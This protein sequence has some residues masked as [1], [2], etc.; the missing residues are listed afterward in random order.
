MSIQARSARDPAHL[1]GLSRVSSPIG[2]SRDA[3]LRALAS[4][5]DFMGA[6]TEPAPLLAMTVAGP[7]FSLV[8]NPVMSS[9]LGKPAG[10][11]TR[12]LGLRMT[13]AAAALP[14]EVAAF[15]ATQRA[16][17]H[18]IKPESLDWRPEALAQEAGALGLTLALFKTHG[19]LAQVLL[20]NSLKVFHPM[21]SAA[22][23]YSGIYHSHY[24]EE[25]LGWRETSAWDQ[26]LAHSLETFLQLKG[27]GHL[28]HRMMGPRY[29]AWVASLEARAEQ[30][31][32]KSR[33]MDFQ[34]GPLSRLA[35][36]FQP[37]ALTATGWP[38]PVPQDFIVKMSRRPEDESAPRTPDSSDSPSEPRS[39]PEILEGQRLRSALL[40]TLEIFDT[41]R[42][43]AVRKR[44]THDLIAHEDLVKELLAEKFQ[45]MG[46][47]PKA[48]PE[49]VEN[50]LVEARRLHFETVNHK[51]FLMVDRLGFLVAEL[52]RS[53]RQARGEE[54]ENW[55][56]LLDS[57]ELKQWE[58]A[59]VY[60]EGEAVLAN[61]AGSKKETEFSAKNYPSYRRYFE[62]FQVRVREYLSRHAEFVK[63]LEAYGEAKKLGTPA[64]LKAEDLYPMIAKLDITP[65]G[66]GLLRDALDFDPFLQS[67]GFMRMERVLIRLVSGLEPELF[68]ELLQPL[69]GYL[70]AL[71]G[72]RPWL[73]RSDWKEIVGR[74]YL[75]ESTDHP[76]MLQELAGRFEQKI[77]ERF[78]QSGGTSDLMEARQALRD[79]FDR[80]PDLLNLLR[81]HRPE[82][83][84]LLPPLKWDE[85]KGR[86]KDRV[87]QG[88]VHPDAAA[89]ILRW[90]EGSPGNPPD[91]VLAQHKSESLAGIL[92]FFFHPSRT[93]QEQEEFNYLL[94]E[95]CQRE[96]LAMMKSLAIR[97]HNYHR[98]METRSR[99]LAK[100]DGSS[101][102][103]GNGRHET[104]RRA[105]LEMA[106]IYQKYP[107]FRG[108]YFE[109]LE[110]ALDRTQPHSARLNAPIHLGILSRLD[111]GSSVELL[112]HPS[113]G[114]EL[115]RVS[116]RGEDHSS[117]EVI[118]SIQDNLD[119]RL[120]FNG[121]MKKM[122]KEVEPEFDGDY[123]MSLYIPRI[124]SEG[125]RRDVLTWA[126]D[127]LEQRPRLQYIEVYL[128]DPARGKAVADPMDAKQY[129][130]Y[131]VDRLTSTTE[132]R[133]KILKTE[134][135]GGSRDVGNYLSLYQLLRESSPMVDLESEAFHYLSEARRQFPDNKTVAG[136]MWRVLNDNYLF[137]YFLGH[138]QLSDFEASDIAR[139]QTN[140]A[141]LDLMARD[142]MQYRLH[143]M[144]KHYERLQARW[145]STPPSQRENDLR[146]I[147]DLIFRAVDVAVNSKS[148]D[149]M[150]REGMLKALD[151]KD[152]SL[153]SA[154][155]F[156]RVGVFFEAV[157]GQPFPNLNLKEVFDLSPVGYETTHWQLGYD[158]KRPNRFTLRA[159]ITPDGTVQSPYFRRSSPND[160]N[161]GSS[162]Q[163]YGLLIL[164][165]E[166]IS[167]RGET[168]LVVQDMRMPAS[169]H[170][171]G[172]G[173]LLTER[174]ITLGQRLGAR[175]LVFKGAE[176]SGKYALLKMGGKVPK[177]LW[178]SL[179][180]SFS[181]FVDLQIQEHNLWGIDPSA[182]A[183]L[184]SGKEIANAYF[185]TMLQKLTVHPRWGKREGMSDV[186]WADPEVESRFQVGRQFFQQKGFLDWDITFDLRPNSPSMADFWKYYRHRFNLREGEILQSPPISINGQEPPPQD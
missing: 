167:N 172:V 180:S 115:V 16:V 23:M 157:L 100:N 178:R 97:F 11:F 50:F 82:E 53:K 130:P 183:S 6:L 103:Q 87:R 79:Y 1:P 24:L 116:K 168:R 62:E 75:D 90:V 25:K 29:G 110:K 57:A 44:A 42:E 89:Q 94:M 132:Q 58:V 56:T 124:R 48:I 9:L 10:L 148:M 150:P 93:I 91:A 52:R 142:P 146:E 126:R 128:P 88:M 45:I 136:E 72:V 141:S 181:Q 8:R 38:H 76:K 117:M 30:E 144:G 68:L 112:S 121:W 149:P 35:E 55:G 86:L 104:L 37:H 70:G 34:G 18:L 145:N 177:E 122:T 102:E 77:E 46:V 31:I 12:G 113:L 163:S 186:F 131:L 154:D 51:N 171:N 40:S 7:A 156:R 36:L 2:S 17:Q 184:S 109:I 66:R 74:E 119:R 71:R 135:R 133:I 63:I 111:K 67:D 160:P 20:P 165:V 159:E 162:I 22:G 169:Q 59:R 78:R 125:I 15:G 80:L 101:T 54:K 83:L 41:S 176:N 33:D 95:I 98:G 179:R 134:L 92:E 143:Q 105:L 152:L 27:M 182:V 14:V 106:R 26:R 161:Q 118:G 153:G 139:N 73:G 39:Q 84:H 140:L 147:R 85:V 185:D 19:R 99:Y 3:D 69:E 81:H 4:L 123:Q 170:G 32:R 65:E 120:A 5:H 28:S 107:N 175:Y 129:I 127:F 158:L 138:N 47:A 155:H 96:D 13:A 164:R 61:S 137:M 114:V 173:T 108:P 43:D 49:K 151:D 64:S 174:L 21:A 60:G 166:G